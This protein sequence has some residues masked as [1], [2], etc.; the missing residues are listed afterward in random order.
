MN[1]IKSLA[2]A[3]TAFATSQ[4]LA[5]HL[6]PTNITKLESG[7]K[8]QALFEANANNSN[9]GIQQGWM[10]LYTDRGVN[11]GPV[12]TVSANDPLNMGQVLGFSNL[13]LSKVNTYQYTI[14]FGHMEELSSNVCVG[15]FHPGANVL[16]LGYNPDKSTCPVD[17]SSS[18]PACFLCK[19]NP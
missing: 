6:A 17:G 2:L 11:L 12:S 14:A 15:E 16:W 13:E 19:I 8:L 7:S 4:A 9:T 1:K 10:Y 3:L 5:F 18:N